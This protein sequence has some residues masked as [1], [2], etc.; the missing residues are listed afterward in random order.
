M[1][2]LGDGRDK[3]GTWTLPATGSYSTWQTATE[4][5]FLEWGWQK[6]RLDILNG[7]FNLT[8]GLSPAPNGYM[9]NGNL[10]F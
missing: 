2:A 10:T 9:A 6:L 7:G 5:A 3:T 4:Q 1:Q 8:D